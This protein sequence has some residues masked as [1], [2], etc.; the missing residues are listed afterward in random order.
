M[1]PRVCGTAA[2]G[3]AAS[4]SA[5]LAGGA[6]VSSRP[7]GCQRRNNL[8]EQEA[9]FWAGSPGWGQRWTADSSHLLGLWAA[10]SGVE[11]AVGEWQS[12]NH[13]LGLRLV[14]RQLQRRCEPPACGL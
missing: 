5:L 4:P 7:F 3:A 13:P 2:L 8:V 14:E 11:A 12:P 6:S 9:Q 1:A 10:F